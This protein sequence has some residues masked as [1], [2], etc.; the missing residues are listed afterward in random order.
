MNTKFKKNG[1]ELNPVKSEVDTNKSKQLE[2]T[3]NREDCIEYFGENGDEFYN[4]WH[5][6][7]YSQL[8]ENDACEVN[9]I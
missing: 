1:N 9:I 5:F 7:S 4:S 6:K 8:I 2:Q 3:L